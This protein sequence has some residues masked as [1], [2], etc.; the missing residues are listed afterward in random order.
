MEGKERACWE[1]HWFLTLQVLWCHHSSHMLWWRHHFSHMLWWRHH[2]SHILWWRHH[3]SHMLW[4]RHH[5]SHILW[6]RHH[7][8]IYYDN[9]IILLLL[10]CY[11]DVIIFSYTMMTSSSSHILWWR[12]HPSRNLWMN[13][14]H[15]MIC[16]T[17][18]R[19]VLFYPTHFVSSFLFFFYLP[20]KYI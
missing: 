3:P 2:P 20:T 6:W 1:T 17:L 7:L 14:Y 12:H 8:L 5:S 9:V 15:V 16:P 13:T 11:D 4:W 10:I 18:L 19:Y